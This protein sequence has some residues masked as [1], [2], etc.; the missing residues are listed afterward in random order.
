MG[1][2]LYS[3][4]RYWTKNISILLPF[5]FLKLYTI[6]STIERL[7][8]RAIR[9]YRAFV[10]AKQIVGQD[11]RNR[12]YE[13]RKFFQFL[14]RTDPS[15]PPSFSIFHHGAKFRSDGYPLEITFPRG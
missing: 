13:E 3:T 11:R 14:T 5:D 6:K 9:F 2:T 4:N 7:E 12:D 8:M 15:S 10:A 1:F